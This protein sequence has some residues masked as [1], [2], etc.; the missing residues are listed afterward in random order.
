MLDPIIARQLAND[1]PRP[2]LQRVLATFAEDLE[3]LVAQMEAAVASGDQEACR[4]A[5]HGL[6][7]A[8]AGLGALTLERTARQLIAPPPGTDPRELVARTRSDGA[9]ALVA[10]N[11]LAATPAPAEEGPAWA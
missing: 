6:A 8:A 4:R 2:G 3:R 11:A 9:A 1:I 5:A 10:L 7:G